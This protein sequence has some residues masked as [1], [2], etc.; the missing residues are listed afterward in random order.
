MDN[1]LQVIEAR[2]PWWKRVARAT[3]WH[4]DAVP[5]EEWKD[6]WDVRLWLPLYDGVVI[7]AGLWAT[8][9]GSP[10]L[11]RLFDAQTIDWAGIVFAFAGVVALAGVVFPALW[12][13][14]LTGKLLIIGLIGT[15]GAAVLLFPVERAPESAFVVFMLAL[16]LFTPFSRLTKLGENWKQRRAEEDADESEGD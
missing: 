10:L 11:H 14:E 9:W 12:K 16:G 5:V 7:G 13:T 8:A 4:P 6:R 2:A 1:R 15:Y 3:I